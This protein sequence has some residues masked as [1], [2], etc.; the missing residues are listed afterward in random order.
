MPTDNDTLTTAEAVALLRV[1]RPQFARMIH[2]YGFTK[3][4]EHTGRGNQT[5]WHA[6]R[7]RNV[8]EAR[9]IYKPQTNTP[10]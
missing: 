1:S 6:E 10:E 4:E 8:A 2:T 5:I 9:R 3:A 7:I